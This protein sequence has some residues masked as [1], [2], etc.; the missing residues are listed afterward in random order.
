MVHN[1]GLCRVNIIT[2][3]TYSLLESL[4]PTSYPAFQNSPNISECLNSQTVYYY[5]QNEKD[6]KS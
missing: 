2:I 3:H 5:R 1:C 6:Q 4:Y